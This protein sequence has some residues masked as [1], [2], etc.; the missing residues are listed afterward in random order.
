MVKMSELI[1]ENG[2]LSEEAKANPYGPQNA[3]K[4][5]LEELKWYSDALAAARAAS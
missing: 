3:L 2:N 4:T 5:M 1:D